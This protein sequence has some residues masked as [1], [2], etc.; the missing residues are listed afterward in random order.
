[1][2]INK[3][4]AILLIP[5]SLA[6]LFFVYPKKTVGNMP[7]SEF[8]ES[9]KGLNLEEREDRI[10]QE[11]RRGNVPEFLLDFREI[12]STFMD[13]RGREHEV[14][15]RVTTDYLSIGNDSDYCR[16]PMGPATAQKIADKSSCVLP[17]TKLSDDIWKHADIKLEPIPYYPVGDNNSK[18]YKFIEHN[19]DINTARDSAGGRPGDLIAGIKKDVVICN[20]IADKPD[21]VAIYGWHYR[22][23]KAIQPLYT[24]HVNWYVD[25]SHGI[26]LI[27]E[28]VLIDGRPANAHEILKDPVLFKLLSNE[29]TPMCQTRYPY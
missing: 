7:G 12:T 15:Y 13:A 27:D 24:G 28:T 1:M 9:I 2:K 25:Y 21:K 6:V 29:A 18:V 4:M 5:L 8:M 14:R 22:S 3:I 19:T 23:G 16:I 10:Y 11:I 20:A 17:T 26:R